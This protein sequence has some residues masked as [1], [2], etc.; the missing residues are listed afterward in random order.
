[1]TELQQAVN[2]NNE[3][4]KQTGNYLNADTQLKHDFD[5]AITQ[6]QQALDHPTGSNLT[7][8]QI[9][10]LKDAI[11]H[12]KD[13]LN[14]NQRLND[15]KS[16]A[17]NKLDQLTH[18][19]NAQKQMAEQ[20]INSANTL[21]DV[22]KAAQ[23]A[24][25][26]DKSMDALNQ[27]VQRTEAPV[28]ASSNYIDA[29]D[30]LKANYNATLDRA[31]NVLN[32]AQGNAL[33][34]DEVESLQQE[35]INAENAL[36]GDQNVSK[37]KGKADQFIDSLENLNPNQRNLAHQLV[38]QADD[39]DTLNDIINNQI[40]LN[41]AM[42]VLKDIVNN[43]V[44]SSEN[45]IK[46]QNADDN[47]KANFTQAK[48]DAI[49]LLKGTDNE[50]G[51][52]NDIQGAIQTLKE[53]INHLNGDSRLQDAKNKA[54]QMINKALADKINDIEAT[55]A[56]DQDKIDAKNKAEALANQTINNIN[57]ATTNQAVD[58]V[59]NNGSQAIAQIHANEIPK[60]QNDAKQDINQH[61]QA[62]I[63]AID[64]NSNLSDAE[65]DALKA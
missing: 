25:T 27:Y 9:N 4:T 34:N 17:L 53:V 11:T 22:A 32:K 12:T 57:K 46:Y 20:Q 48:D 58:N 7:T 6:A 64:H 33:T 45:S 59:E 2:D 24:T 14:G 13:A 62:L 36:N 43:D 60:A 26:L 16:D 31:H 51:D 29:D 41:D 50:V 39:L 52:T 63:D 18:L 65:K 3:P 5:E 23:K 19:N 35:I 44:P 38:A 49:K 61:S 56:T 47:A 15:S 42:K 54:I 40:D 10:Q 28:K 55:N 30:E 21:G 8:D 1:M 37:A